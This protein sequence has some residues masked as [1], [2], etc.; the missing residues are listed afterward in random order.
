MSS[1]EK[2]CP[3]C[4]KSF[5]TGPS[6]ASIFCSIRCKQIDL[7]RWLSGSYAVSGEPVLQGSESSINGE[8]E[9]GTV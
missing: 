3:I 2:K 8:L 1:I 4:H 6:N 5:A 9:E 7:H